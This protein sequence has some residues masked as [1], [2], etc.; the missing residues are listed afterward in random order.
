MK[1]F[2]PAKGETVV[3]NGEVTVKVLEIRGD[4]VLLEIDAPAW[5]E[6]RRE[7]MP[8]REE[9]AAPALPR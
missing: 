7:E 3:V 6:I 9:D 5:V 4:E 8:E 2:F 1:E